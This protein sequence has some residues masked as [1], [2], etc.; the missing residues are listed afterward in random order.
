M[1]LINSIRIAPCLLATIAACI[2]GCASKP[3]TTANTATT[4][5]AATTPQYNNQLTFARPEDAV[6][7]LAEAVKAQDAAPQLEDIFGSDSRATLLSGDPVADRRN[8][9]VIAVAMSEGWTLNA[10]NSNT[11]E[12]VIGNE[13]WPFPIPL[14]KDSRGWWFDTVAG[15]E[16]IRDRR[17][18]RN[19]LSTID[20]LR[21]YC[22]AQ[23]EYAQQGRDGGPAGV[24]A[25][26]IKSDPGKH[27]GLYWPRGNA[28]EA[29]S[30]LGEF[31]A[32]AS[33]EGYGTNKEGAAPYHGYFYRIL[34]KQ[35]PA[36][37]GG[38][39]DYITNG[40]MS[41]GF[42]MIAFPADYGNSGIMTFLVGPDGVVYQSD[43]G[44]DTKTTAGAIA[45]YDPGS[46]WQKVQ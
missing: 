22:D 28:K 8:R 24:Y 7:K 20:T 19:E 16:E 35:G 33:A 25:Q 37:S 10:T 30:P 18:G 9:E 34:K 29:D 21:A 11:R 45:A 41:G 14:V 40:T 23:R 12:L 44:N 2:G 4:A 1:T 15:K 39:K 26:Q 17:I 27:N 42:A 46:N 3:Q 32:T 6:K 5:T 36:A 31:V 38:A 43:L 13:K